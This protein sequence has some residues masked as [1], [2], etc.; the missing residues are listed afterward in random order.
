[1]NGGWYRSLHYNSPT[2]NHP[3]PSVTPFS[4]VAFARGSASSQSCLCESL[5]CCELLFCSGLHSEQ[6]GSVSCHKWRGWYC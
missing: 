2:K 5:G 3:R 4:A 1:M 6:A